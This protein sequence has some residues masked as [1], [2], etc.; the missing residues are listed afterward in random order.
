MPNFNDGRVISRALAALARQSRPPDE[1]VVYDDGST[2]NS[3]EII[4]RYQKKH[5]FIHLI[6]GGRRIGADAVL[7]EIAPGAVT[8]DYVYFASANDYVLPGFFERA[9]EWAIRYPLAGVIF[10]AMVVADGVHN[11]TA[12]VPAWKSSRYVSPADYFN[13][14][15]KKTEPAHALGGATIYRRPALAEAGWF[16]SGLGVLSDTVIPRVLALRFGAVYLARPCSVWTCDSASASQQAAAHP[17]R[18]YPLLARAARLMRSPAY[19]TLFPADYVRG[20]EVSY[21]RW[22]MTN[23]FNSRFKLEWRGEEP[24][25]KMAVKMSETAYRIRVSLGS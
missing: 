4:R 1:L 24:A 7:R 2:D 12:T 22:V 21:R 8:G 3:R 6:E 14:Y 17:A 23:Y 25:A 20:W 15:L 19:S 18:A 5:S 11:Q 13:Q 10:G 9:V 16:L